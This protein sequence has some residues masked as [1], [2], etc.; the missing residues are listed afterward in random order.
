MGSRLIVLKEKG[1][2]PKSSIKAKLNSK[3][4]P[5]SRDLDTDIVGT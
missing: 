5:C 2:Y 3:T 1:V 4:T